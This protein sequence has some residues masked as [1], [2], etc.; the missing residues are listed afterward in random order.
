MTGGAS[1]IDLWDS[2]V[3]A[4][5]LLSED[6]DTFLEMSEFNLELE[7]FL[8]ASISVKT[9]Q[10]AADLFKSVNVFE[11]VMFMLFFGILMLTGLSTF[12]KETSLSNRCSSAKFFVFLNHVVN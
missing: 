10:F 6:F 9:S 7:L 5:V 1:W 2:S 4:R 3:S 12:T 8:S 11:D